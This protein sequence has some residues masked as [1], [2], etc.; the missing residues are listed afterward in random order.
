M[1]KHVGDGDRLGGWV[2]VGLLGFFCAYNYEGA[3]GLENH[4]K[5]K[6]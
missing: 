2:V 6:T 4:Q 3:L 1:V 5:K